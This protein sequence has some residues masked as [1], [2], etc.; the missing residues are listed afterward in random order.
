MKEAFDLLPFFKIAALILA[1]P[2]IALGGRFIVS[3]QD[4]RNND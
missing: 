4:W 2:A 1:I 3:Y